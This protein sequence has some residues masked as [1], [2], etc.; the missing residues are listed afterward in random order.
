[1]GDKRHHEQLLPNAMSCHNGLMAANQPGWYNDPWGLAAVR[2]WDGYQWTPHTS[3][4]PASMGMVYTGD[5]A[6][7]HSTAVRMSKWARVA[8]FGTAAFFILDAVSQVV[9]AS[10]YTTTTAGT[11]TEVG[12]VLAISV[13]VLLVGLAMIPLLVL[14]LIW[15]YNAAK[16]A[17]GLGYPSRLSPGLG[18]G[19]W[20][21]PIVSLW[22]PHWALSDLL[23]RDHPFRGKALAAWWAYVL[24][25]VL[26]YIT[27]QLSIG[28]VGVA[29]IP[30]FLS[31][32]LIVIAAK[33]GLQCFD[34]VQ[35]DHRDK[36]AAL[37]SPAHAGNQY[38]PWSQYNQWG[39]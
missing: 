37:A 23:P 19:S 4:T 36:L 17:R 39:S 38:N 24:T 13:V 29:L 2:W 25:P 27:P 35:A 9:K 6:A 7:A 12:S 33:L 30:A 8:I 5:I 34:A 18:V 26:T 15:Q 28:S 10:L 32:C 21:I 11:L 16:V 14:F 1:M 20:F 22:F 31:T 3:T